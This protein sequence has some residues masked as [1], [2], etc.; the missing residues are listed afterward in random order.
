MAT[1]YTLRLI[2]AAL[3]AVGCTTSPAMAKSRPTTL[4]GWMD[5]ELV[6]YLADQLA[7]HPRFEG[8]TV[9][10]VA[11][12]DGAPAPS[13]NA[14]V[15]ALRDRLIDTLDDTPGIVIGWQTGRG[16]AQWNVGDIDCTRDAVHY[17]IGLEVA[18][19]LD[20]RHRVNM[21]VL[22]AEDQ[23]WVAGTGKTWEGRLTSAQRRAFEQALTDE[24][25]RGERDVPFSATQTDML[26]AHLAH[27]LACKLLRQTDGEYVIAAAESAVA[28]AATP[29]AGTIELVGNNLAGTPSLQISSRTDSANAILEGK[30]HHIDGDLYQY[31]VTVTPG[32]DRPRL[33]TISASAYVR[34]SVAAA[35]RVTARDAV[36]QVAPRANAALLAPIRVL[37]PR[38]RR[39]CYQ[40]GSSRWRQQLVTADFTVR[41]GECFLLQT[42]ANRN[43]TVFLL[44][45]QVSRGLVRLS[46]DQCGPATRTITALAGERLQFPATGDR[47]PS[48]SAWQGTQGVESFYVV[49]VSDPEAARE[50]DML[51][52]RLPSRC[53][54]SAADGLHGSE[55]RDWL[56][57][58][59]AVVDRWQNR[60]DWQAVRVEHIY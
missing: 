51:I 19:L 27:E 20:G 55:L 17:Y 42:H 41:R 58:F 34:V 14:L 36:A 54:L 4:T 28:S 40:G 35:K 43:A 47:R 49:A 60:V 31:W 46:G 7:E 18:P 12:D 33:P 48:A 2:L 13:T 9:V 32:S 29:L 16:G 21:R 59:G 10:F 30:A 26:A 22:D 3:I 1:R 5:R 45:Y 8:E 39:A 37:E 24:Y 23:S 15:L 56:H 6:P 25:F 57:T 11:F 44:N 52:D 53:T 50:V 38:Q